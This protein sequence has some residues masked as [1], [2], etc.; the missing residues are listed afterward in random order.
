MIYTINGM[1]PHSRLG[2]KYM[3][4]QATLSQPLNHDIIN[5]HKK[6]YHTFGF[7]ILKALLPALLLTM[8]IALPAHADQLQDGKAAYMDGD[9]RTALK[10][11]RPLA[12]QGNPNAQVTIGKIYRVNTSRDVFRSGYFT[13]PHDEVEAM[14]WFQQA[15]KQGDAE[16]EW[17]IGILYDFGHPGIKGDKAAA[18]KWCLKSANDGYPV[19]QH[20]VGRMYEHGELGLDQNYE[21]ALK[22]YSKAAS[23]TNK[24]GSINAQ[25]AIG[26]MY[27]RGSGVKQDYVQAYMWYSLFPWPQVKALSSKMTPAQIADGKRLVAKWKNAHPAPPS[28]P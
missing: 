4:G 5:L 7:A 6:R 12:E 1:E 24:E 17:Q 28:K 21:E 8:F 25:Y 10:L 3:L 14:K 22:W 26:R 19:A 23:Q 27:E 9:W 11:L 16:A 20:S 15:A 18:K 2:I 13:V